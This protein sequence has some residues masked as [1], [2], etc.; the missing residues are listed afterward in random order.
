MDPGVDIDLPLWLSAVIILL[1]LVVSA[2]LS[3]AETALTSASRPRLYALDR[4]GNLR[5]FSNTDMGYT[6]RHSTAPDDVIFTQA[7]FQGRPGDTTVIQAAMDDIADKRKRSQPPAPKASSTTART[8]GWLWL[9]TASTTEALMPG[10][11]T[12]LVTANVGRA[13]A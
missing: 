7:L 2:L 11:R 8:S 10:L 4:K 5:T 6:Y 13:S 9:I 1:L 12:R 3:V